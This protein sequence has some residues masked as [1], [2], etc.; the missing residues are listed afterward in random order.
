M[1]RMLHPIF[2]V[3]VS[4]LAPFACKQAGASFSQ[5]DSSAEFTEGPA[6]STEDSLRK[7]KHPGTE[8]A[9]VAQA[10]LAR[11]FTGKAVLHVNEVQEGFHD[12]WNEGKDG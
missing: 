2:Y 7:I 12:P 5:T 8:I 6:A 11:R 4:A 9:N 3:V 1:H 10:L